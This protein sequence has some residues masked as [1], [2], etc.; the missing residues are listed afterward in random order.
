MTTKTAHNQNPI[1]GINIFSGAPTELG[2]ALTN[3]TELAREKECVRK[4]YSVLFAGTRYADAESAYHQLGSAD[5]QQRDQLMVELIAAKLTQHP[6][7]QVQIHERGGVAFLT[8]CTHWTNASS[9]KGKAWEGAG[10]DS[11]FIRNLVAGYLLA[12]TGCLTENAQH[13]L[14]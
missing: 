7:L 3:P 4:R 10:L 5:P 8:A 12:E 11:R 9:E 6:E 2:A 13:A 14:F 1:V